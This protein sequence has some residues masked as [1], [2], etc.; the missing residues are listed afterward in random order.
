MDSSNTTLYI[1]TN[2][3]FN[4]DLGE[5]SPSGSLNLGG[6]LMYFLNKNLVVGGNLYV[7]TYI[8]NDL[9]QSNKYSEKWIGINPYIQFYPNICNSSCNKL[10]VRAN[11]SL[12]SGKTK[13]S[14]LNDDNV[15]GFGENHLAIGPGISFNLK[16]NRIFNIYSSLLSLN[17]FTYRDIDT[18]EK[19]TYTRFSGGLNSSPRF[20]SAVQ[21]IFWMELLFPLQSK[22]N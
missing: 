1:G 22:K 15:T 3:G 11:L 12:N 8:Y 19:T 18:G 16:K 4:F 10:F 5:Q 7:G 2:S 17:Q 21:P 9:F 14:Y 20:S 13:Q 6:S